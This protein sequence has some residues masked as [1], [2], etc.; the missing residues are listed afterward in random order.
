MSRSPNSSWWMSTRSARVV[1]P[2]R[3]AS[4]DR[5]GR[6]CGQLVV[7]AERHV[8][9]RDPR[10]LVRVE[11]VRR[12][13][14]REDAR[15][16]VPVEPDQLLL[17]THLAVVAREAAGPLGR[18]EPVA[19]DPAEHRGAPDPA[20]SVRAA[21]SS[22]R[23]P[24]PRIASSSATALR[25]RSHVVHPHDARAVVERP[26]DGGQRAVVARAGAGSPVSPPRSRSNAPRKRFRDVPTTTGPSTRGHELG[27][28]GE[29]QRDCARPSC[30]SRSRDRRSTTRG[31]SPAASAASTRSTRQSPT[32][33]TTSS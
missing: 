18:R 24:R 8:L 11:V 10:F 5:R 14:Q 22:C 17:A 20:P 4:V 13:E 25:R 16:P 12:V 33:A 23:V 2:S 3:D 27:E 30:R 15:E 28:L 21:A 9:V 29:E 31:R 26:D 1:E 19:D 32:S 7:P 6:L